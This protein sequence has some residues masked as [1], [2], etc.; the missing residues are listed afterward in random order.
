[1]T[2]F[3]SGRLHSETSFMGKQSGLNV[4][5]GTNQGWDFQEHSNI[6]M[7]LQFGLNSFY[8]L[9]QKKSFS[10]ILFLFAFRDEAVC[11]SDFGIFFYPNLFSS[12]L[13]NSSSSLFL[14]SD[15][16]TNQTNSPLLC[17][18][19]H[20]THLFVFCHRVELFSYYKVTSENRWR[21]N[22]NR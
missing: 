12:H 11:V 18:S 9:Q 6:F 8:G 2:L 4:E 13:V 20:S 15:L 1:M 10:L 16:L 21:N 17:S 22:Q 5:N 19:E 7:L 14:L 3:A